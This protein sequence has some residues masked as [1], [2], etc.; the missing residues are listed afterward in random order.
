MAAPLVLCTACLLLPLSAQT[1]TPPPAPAPP[2]AAPFM[3]CSGG[4]LPLLAIAASNP[5]SSHCIASPPSSPSRLS[6]PDAWLDGMP[7]VSESAAGAVSVAAWSAVW[8]P[9]APTLPRREPSP[10]IMLTSLVP[11]PPADPE[12]AATTADS[13]SSIP[14]RVRG[15]GAAAI[16]S[17]PI[18]LLSL[19][20]GLCAVLRGLALPPLLRPTPAFAL[21]FDAA[22]LPTPA[23]APP[24]TACLFPTP[25]LPPT[26]PPLALYPPPLFPPCLPA[27]LLPPTPPPFTGLVCLP[28]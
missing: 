25:S 8:L 23:P 1:S 26:L 21:T 19:P 2:A 10:S 16:S 13:L 9:P 6:C 27:C 7:S 24:P 5:S 18:P 11:C 4:L 15:V 22:S 20:D 28:G 17:C 14:S 3:P 12:S